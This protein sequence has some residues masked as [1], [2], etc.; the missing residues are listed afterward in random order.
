MLVKKF[1]IATAFV[2]AL[3]AAGCSVDI[4]GRDHFLSFDFSGTTVKVSSNGAHNTLELKPYL[5]ASGAC[6]YSVLFANR[7]AGLI[8]VVLDASGRS[9][10]NAEGPCAAGSE[11]SLIWL[12]LDAALH[13]QDANSVLVESCLNNI[14]GAQGYAISGN[15]LTMKYIRTSVGTEGANVASRQQESELK[16]DNDHPEA[17]LSVETNKV[18]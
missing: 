3:L 17:G 2:A 13:I 10:A 16:Y 14:H 8:Y 15:Q 9:S 1:M 4:L 11:Q 7:R 18:K 5:A 12:K 6:G